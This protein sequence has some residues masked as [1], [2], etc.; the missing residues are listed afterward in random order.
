MP[1]RVRRQREPEVGG[2]QR[3]RKWGGS[4]RGQGAGY[5]QVLITKIL[6][7]ALRWVSSGD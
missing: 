4:Q 2:A 5:W 1:A 6:A 3:Y 7:L